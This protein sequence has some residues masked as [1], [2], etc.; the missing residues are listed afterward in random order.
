M[1][2]G[3]LA[4]DIDLGGHAG[5]TCHVQDIAVALGRA[6]CMVD[7]VV[8]KSAE[9]RGHESVRVL[10]MPHRRTLSAAVG[11]RRAW[12]QRPPDVLYERRLTP[13][14]SVVL[15]CLLSRPFF[16]EINGLVDEE[17]L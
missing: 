15:S 14:L 13:K 5:D 2:L 3:F 4:P 10:A 9:W 11:L 8:A 12:R 16:V 7:L 1:H 6:G 17:R